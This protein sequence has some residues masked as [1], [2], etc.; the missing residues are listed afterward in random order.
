MGKIC[1]AALTWVFS[2]VTTPMWMGVC[3]EFRRFIIYP[4]LPREVSKMG[5]M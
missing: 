5:S 4:Y 1:F 3:L 2:E